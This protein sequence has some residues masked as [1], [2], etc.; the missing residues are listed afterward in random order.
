MSKVKICKTHFSPSRKFP[1]VMVSGRL[2][3]FFRSEEEMDL[4]TH[5]PGRLNFD[6]QPD[7]IKKHLRESMPLVF[8][9]AFPETA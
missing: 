4:K 9:V 5:F 2:Q 7:W 3:P 8:V 1:A 6:Y